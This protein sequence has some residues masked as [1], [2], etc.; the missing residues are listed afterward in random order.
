M[1]KLLVAVIGSMILSACSSGGGYDN[2]VQS[3]TDDGYSLEE[4]Q[5]LCQEEA[6]DSQIQ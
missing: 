4:A 6:Y 2:C 1:K 3:M 5:D